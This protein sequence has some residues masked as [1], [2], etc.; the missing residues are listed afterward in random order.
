MLIFIVFLLACGAFGEHQ[1][2][3][4]LQLLECLRPLSRAPLPLHRPALRD[5]VKREL[6]VRSGPF[7]PES[8]RS[9][10]GQ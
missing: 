2:D 8:R 4:Q 10:S 3:P 1:G 7:S 5:I 9:P 6:R